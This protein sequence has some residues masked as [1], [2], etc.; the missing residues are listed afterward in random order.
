MFKKRLIAHVHRPTVNWTPDTTERGRQR[1]VRDQQEA[2]EA[3]SVKQADV[4]AGEP[5]AYSRNPYGESLLTAAIPMEN[6]YCSCKL[7]RVR[8]RCSKGGHG[9]G[10]DVRGG[11][12][13][14]EGEGCGGGDGGEGGAAGWR[15]AL[16]CSHF[17]AASRD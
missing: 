4:D 11:G 10:Q 16:F 7:T 6:P 13:G 8:S 5:L 14:G 17:S 2:E 12:C 15:A 9:R 3:A 1:S